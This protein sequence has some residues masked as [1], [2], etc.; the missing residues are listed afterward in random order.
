MYAVGGTNNDVFCY[1]LTPLLWTKV[2]GPG[3]MF[4]V[5]DLGRLYGLTPDGKAV[6][7]Y[8][9][10]WNALEKWTK[11]G[12][13]AGKIFAGGNGRLFATNPQTHELRTYE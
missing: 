12:D 3:K 7:R 8:D 6:N 5:D 2:G 1:R 13:V 10:A 4:A 9:G 11:I